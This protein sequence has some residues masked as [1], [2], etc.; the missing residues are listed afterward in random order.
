MRRLKFVNRRVKKIGKGILIG[1]I[2]TI[3]TL[4][5][6]VIVLFYIFF[7]GGPAKITRDINKYESVLSQPHIQTAYIVFP[8]KLPKGVLETEFYNYY[9]DTFGSPTLQTYLKC[10][11]DDESYY[12]E[13]DRLENTSKTYG[14]NQ[15]KLLRDE[16]KKFQYP[17]YIA[18]ENAA[19]KYEYALLTG[20]NEITYICTCYIDREDVKFSKDY[21]PYD[22]MTEEGRAYGS[23]Y[24]IY[25][26]SVS[27]S[28][29]DIDYTRDPAPEVRDGHLRMIGDDSF[30][31][32]VRL[33]EQGREI[34]TECA[35]FSYAPETEEEKE[36]LYDDLNGMQYKNM[37]VDRNQGTIV[38][39]Y[40]DGEE[41]KTK[42][43]R[44]KNY[45][46]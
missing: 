17:A 45:A 40:I 6:A 30:I 22:F 29:I 8:E 33:D 21:L 20:N 4:F 5:A 42:E 27:S 44:A 3:V 15:K 37:E 26:A 13:I 9:R 28:M 16:E 39:I 35:L 43:F 31:V 12:K 23:G 1:I 41:E 38:V 2:L 46:E 7:M 14:N 18:V 32:R 25:Y 36:I 11:Y 24:S 19:H 34:I 10:V